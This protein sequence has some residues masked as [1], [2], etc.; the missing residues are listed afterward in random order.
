MF[1]LVRVRR[2]V[3]TTLVKMGQ[4]SLAKSPRRMGARKYSSLLKGPCS[5]ILLETHLR[6]QHVDACIAQKCISPDT[7]EDWIKRPQKAS[8]TGSM[9]WTAMIS[10]FIVVGDNLAWNV[11]KGNRLQIGTD[12]WPGNDTSHILPE[13]LTDQL[14]RQGIFY[15]AHLANP[16][17]TNYWNQG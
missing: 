7:I 17:T 8:T 9:I 16:P 12:P 10:S 5:K 15:L 11:G 14:H 4:H 1:H 3:H 13:D 2:K 6:H